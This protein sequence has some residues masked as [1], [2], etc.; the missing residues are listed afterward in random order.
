LFGLEPIVTPLEMRK[1][2]RTSA[3][4]TA[5]AA[6]SEMTVVDDVVDIRVMSSEKR[7]IR[8]RVGET[9]CEVAGALDSG[10]G[11]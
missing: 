8:E 11:L 9:N 10:L 3:E 2:F 7:T 6:G 1:S 5:N 4:R